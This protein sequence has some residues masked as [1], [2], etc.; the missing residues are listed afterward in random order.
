MEDVSIIHSRLKKL[1]LFNR[2]P[3]ARLK[4]P[5]ELIR[6]PQSVQ[7]II[8]DFCDPHGLQRSRLPCHHQLLELAQ[9]RVYWVDDVI[10][11]APT[12]SPPLPAF[13]LI[14]ASRSFPMSQFF[15]SG[16]QSTGVSASASVL[17]MT[18]QDWFP[19]GLTSWIS[20]QTKGL[21]RVF[22]TTVKKHSAL[23]FLYGPILTSIHDSWKTIV[24]PSRE[25]PP[26]WDYLRL[27]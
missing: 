10:Q 5:K 21:S 4:E 25:G 27:D 3:E 11:P 6:P 26:S 2:P 19:L 20:L 23:S 15:A 8:S 18:I 7:T 14:P 13:N 9:T 22:N 16:S 12:L 17:P 1:E 24:H